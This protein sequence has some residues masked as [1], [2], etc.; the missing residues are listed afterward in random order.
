MAF[1]KYLPLFAF[2][3]NSQVDWLSYEGVDLNKII[4]GARKTIYIMS[5]FV[6]CRDSKTTHPKCGLPIQERAPNYHSWPQKFA[7][8][9]F[10][11]Q[12]DHFLA[13]PHVSCSS[14]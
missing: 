11:P 9:N 2:I 6:C 12:R 3:G 1:Q 5:T 13:A 7:L 4:S 10:I 8:I 14:D